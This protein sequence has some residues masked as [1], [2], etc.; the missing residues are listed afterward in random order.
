MPGGPSVR[1]GLGQR[2]QL[3]PPP[4]E[5]SGGGSQD[6]DDKGGAGPLAWEEAGVWQGGDLGRD[7]GGLGLRQRRVLGLCPGFQASGAPSKSRSL[8]WDECVSSREAP[9]GLRTPPAPRGLPPSAEATRAQPERLQTAPAS[10]SA[11]HT[12]RLPADNAFYFLSITVWDG[13][14]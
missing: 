6:R 13:N 5:G 2:H 7:Q 8:A 14:C 4:R 10:S 1:P 12:P 3:Q 11:P 9:A